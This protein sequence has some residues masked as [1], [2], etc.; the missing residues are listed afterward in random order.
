MLS[1][2]VL[3]ASEKK[4]HKRFFNNLVYLFDS[5]IV[6]L[7]NVL[8]HLKKPA[9]KFLFNKRKTPEI[10]NNYE[11]ILVVEVPEVTFKI[12]FYGNVG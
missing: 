10:Y 1:Q 11:C 5:D 7:L 6:M 3:N 9:L 4:W 2:K 8:E 12:S